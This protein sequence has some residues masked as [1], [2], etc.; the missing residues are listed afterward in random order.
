MGSYVIRRHIDAP[1]ERVFRAFTD[2]AL[3]VDW[4]DA[5]TLEEP[6]GPLDRAG[7]QYRLVIFRLHHF[8][9]TVVRS[10]PPLVHETRGSG[11]FGWYRM[12]ATLVPRSGG[13]DLELLTEYGLPL[14]PV[15]RWIDR[16]WIDREPRAQANREVD[17]LV[18]LVSATAPPR[19]GHVGGAPAP[20]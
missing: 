11:R 3:V 9:T 12:V 20:A 16:R 19:A 6:S 5:K 7:T 1:P 10:E 15:G 13:T 4:M 18:E 8:R 14:G 17:R 2:P